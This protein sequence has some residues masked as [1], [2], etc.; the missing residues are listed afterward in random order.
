MIL[1]ALFKLCAYAL[2]SERSVFMSLNLGYFLHHACFRFSM[3]LPAQAICVKAQPW[4]QEVTSQAADNWAPELLVTI[5]FPHHPLLSS[6][7]H[8]FSPPPSPPRASCF[9]PSVARRLQRSCLPRKITAYIY[10]FVAGFELDLVSVAE[11]STFSEYFPSKP[12]PSLAAKELR[13]E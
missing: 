1:A 4:N 7:S 9:P 5:P 6:P 11:G 10:A 8:S 2:G 3:P 12:Q 13:D